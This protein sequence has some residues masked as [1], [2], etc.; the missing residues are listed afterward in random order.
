MESEGAESFDD[1]IN[2]RFEI[3]NID[4]IKRRKS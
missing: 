3:L 4:V 2:L 1:L